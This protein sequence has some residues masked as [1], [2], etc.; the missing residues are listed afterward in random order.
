MEGLRKAERLELSAVL[1]NEGRLAVELRRL[2]IHV[3]VFSEEEHHS[4]L[5]LFRLVKYLKQYRPAI[6]HT[7][8]YKDNILGSIAAVAAGVSTVVRTVHGM[9]EPFTGQAYVKMMG[10]ET[11]DRMVMS[12]KGKRIIAV[13]SDIASVLGRMYGNQKVVRIHNGID[14]DKIAATKD[15]SKVRDELGIGTADFVI[16]TVGRL[17]PVKGHEF[18][19][20]MIGSLKDEISNLKCLIV[21]DGPLLPRLTSLVR[22]LGL[23]RKVML[24][25]NGMMFMI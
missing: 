9:T 24:A 18:L 17:T 15:Q 1:L 3:M 23:E 19:L 8:K 20:R 14:L 2:G 12:L 11:L 13:S 25:G 7:H 21:G 22:D 10:Y 16:G 5:L 4:A 6:V